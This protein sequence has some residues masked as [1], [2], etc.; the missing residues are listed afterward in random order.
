MRNFSIITFFF[1]PIDINNCFIIT[2]KNSAFV[3]KN[4]QITGDYIVQKEQFEYEYLY[5]HV[6]ISFFL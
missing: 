1:L 4:K 2:S 3:S 6:K 5:L